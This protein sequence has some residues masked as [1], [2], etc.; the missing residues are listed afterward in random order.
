MSPGDDYLNKWGRQWLGA[1]GGAI[2]GWGVSAVFPMLVRRYTVLTIVLWC[3]AIGAAL[4]S[5]DNFARAGAA[6][7]RG[8]N[9]S[10]NL[11]V[12]LGVSASILL[13]VML[14]L[15]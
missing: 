12:G 9:R 1:L 10:L 7:T 3:A 8:K 5:M 14:I 2:F 15:R 13:I 4:M 11:L 6:L